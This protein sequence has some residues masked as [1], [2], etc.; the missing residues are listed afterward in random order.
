MFISSLPDIL[1]AMD[2]PTTDGINTYFISHFARMRG[3]KAVLSGLGADELFGGYP[4]FKD[5]PAQPL[6]RWLPRALFK[7]AGWLKSEKLR[8]ISFLSLA[9]DLGNHLMFRGLFA[10]STVASL[11]G[12]SP[13]EVDQKLQELFLG[14]LTANL[15]S[16]NKAS[17]M[18]LSLYMQNQLLRDSDAMSMWHSVELRVPFLDKELIQLVMQLNSNLKF[19]ADRPKDLLIRAF[20]DILPRQIWDRP[21]QGFTFPFQQWMGKEERVKQLHHHA[22][23]LV[24]QM[25]KE[26]DNNQIQWSRIWALVL[27][28]EWKGRKI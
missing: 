18:E 9:D 17:W 13:R 25:A 28:Q 15:S 3:F 24:R 8:K 22:H 16:G 10:P 12:I 19:G 26:F 4:S 14:K 1:S 2:Q 23:P 7:T 20:E 21:K 11:L 6:M 5:V 27:L